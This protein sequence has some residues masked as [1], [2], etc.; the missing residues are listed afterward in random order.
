[1]ISFMDVEHPQNSLMDVEHPQ[2]SFMD[3]EHPQPS[4][5][6]VECPQNHN[7]WILIYKA[8]SIHRFYIYIYIYFYGYIMDIIGVFQSSKFLKSV[9]GWIHS[10]HKINLKKGVKNC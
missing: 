3:V 10:I 7:L 8:P 9:D 5:M 1:M 6:D 2:P 4:F